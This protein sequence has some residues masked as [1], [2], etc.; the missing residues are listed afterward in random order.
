MILIYEFLDL[1]DSNPWLCM[2][3]S[4]SA[5]LHQSLPADGPADGPQKRAIFEYFVPNFHLFIESPIVSSG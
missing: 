3:R 5:D 1:Y 4:L 2:E